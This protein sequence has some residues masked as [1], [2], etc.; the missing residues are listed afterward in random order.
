MR[1]CKGDEMETEG[2]EEKR[3][4]KQTMRKLIS[5]F[6]SNSISE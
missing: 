4:F 6:I 2:K 3:I 5:L 1:D